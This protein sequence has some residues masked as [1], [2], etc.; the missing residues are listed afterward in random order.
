MSSRMELD[1]QQKTIVHGYELKMSLIQLS[2][3]KK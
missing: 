2:A 3:A 1:K